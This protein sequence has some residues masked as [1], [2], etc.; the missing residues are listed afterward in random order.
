MKLPLSWLREWIDVEADAAAIAEALTRR[1]FYVEGIETHGPAFTGVVVARVL[2]VER[3][4]NADKLTLCRVDGGSGELSVVCGAPNVRAG[5]IVPL[6]TIG[7]RLPGGVTIRRSKIRGAESQGML[8]SGRELELNADHQGIVDLERWLDEQG[9]SVERSRLTPGLAFDALMDPP[10]DVLDIEIPFNRPDGM[11]IVGLAREVRAALGGRWTDTG[12]R[13]LGARWSEGTGFDLDLE[14][15]EGCPRYIAQVVERI[16]IAPSPAWLRRRIELLGLRPISNVVDLTNLVLFELGQPLHAFDLDRLRGPAIRVRRARAGER[17]T[18]LDGRERALDPEILVIADAQVPVAI[19]GVM[20]GAASEVHDGT[21]RLLLECAWFE[22]RRIRRGSRQLGLATDASKRFERGVDPGIA[23]IAA[24]RF[25]DLL[26]EVCPGCRLGAGRERMK[27]LPTVPAIHLRPSRCTRVIGRSVDA[28]EAQRHLV[29]LEF[30]VRGED[31]L[32]V[33]VPS[34]RRDIALED[35][36]VEEVAR[37]AGYDSI[38]EAPLE[39]GGTFAVRS[40]EER[41][42]DRA[43]RA[44]LAR[45]LTEACTSALVSAPEAV[46]TANL[47]GLEPARLVRLANPMSREHEVLR[48]NPLAGLLRACGHNLRQGLAAVRL[49]ELGAGYLWPDSRIPRPTR[50]GG[51]SEATQ[52]PAEPTFVAAVVAGPRFAHAHDVLQGETD[53]EDAKGLWEAFLDELGVDAPEWRPYSAPGWKP[54]A[55]AELVCGTSCI[56]WA[57]TLSQGALAAWEIEQPIQAFLVSLDEL[58]AAGAR[59]KVW[60]PGRFPPVRRDVAFFVPAAVSHGRLEQVLREAAG[61][62]L[63]AIDLF[64]VYAGP[65]TPAGMKSMAYAL[66]FQD[67]ARTMTEA[68]VQSIQAQMS[69]AVAEE[70]GGRLRDR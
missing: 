5:M 18:T 67:R 66:Q 1:G 64:D 17:I 23:P 59:P 61:E 46:S 45:G 65:G 63:V 30:A 9:R 22:P 42:I 21:T 43:R 35:D 3:H 51:G 31:P 62:R 60:L 52:L 7:A 50:G 24:R 27:P 55:S 70:C 29:D 6:A 36:L 68:E 32:E 28:A 49:F 53:F 40:P 13:R 57:G 39:T 41:Q 47:V 48:P 37:S 8:C 2:G 26:A 25:L 11:G 38:P 58:P 20:G 56:G 10:D 33:S 4:P 14:D 54:G 19:A 44:M 34:W 16:A 15:D 12:R 69:A